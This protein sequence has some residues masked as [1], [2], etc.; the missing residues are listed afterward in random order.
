MKIY[1]YAI[2]RKTE[3]DLEIPE[4]SILL[5]IQVQNGGIFAWFSVD[6]D[7]PPTSLKILLVGTG[8]DV[9]EGY[10][11]LQH[12]STVQTSDGEYVWHLFTPKETDA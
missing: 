1:K 10:G 8:F 2:V 3:Q 6:P 5:D 7:L 12:L 4:D 9:P 11:E